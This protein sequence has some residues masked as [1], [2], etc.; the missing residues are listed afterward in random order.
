[1]FQIYWIVFKR[2]TILQCIVST[3]PF[4]MMWSDKILTKTSG[5]ALFPVVHA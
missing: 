4:V 2:L 1:M 3:A 5:T